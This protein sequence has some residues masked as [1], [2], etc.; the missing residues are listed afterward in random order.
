MWALY[1]MVLLKSS[2]QFVGSAVTLVK[3]IYF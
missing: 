2:Q 3:T 1:N